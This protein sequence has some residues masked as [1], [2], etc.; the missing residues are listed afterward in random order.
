M[1]SQGPG[2]LDGRRT[3]AFKQEKELVF[4]DSVCFIQLYVEF[5]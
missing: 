2:I 1:K 5:R 4:L 3:L